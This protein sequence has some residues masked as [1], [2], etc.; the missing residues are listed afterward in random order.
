MLYAAD[1]SPAALEV[2]RAKYRTMRAMRLCRATEPDRVRT[3][4]RELSSRFPGALRE[5]DEL[6]LA[7][8]DAR[9]AAIEAAASGRGPV[10]GWAPTL[11]RYH[12]F[13]RVALRLKRAVRRDADLEAVSRWVLDHYRAGPDEPPG[14]EILG[15]AANI[16]RPPS[17]RLSRW[18]LGQIAAREGR[19]LAEVEREAFPPS[20]M[21]ARPGGRA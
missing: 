17:G 12:G 3:D 21:R 4:M 13:M 5:L 1:V 2:L 14:D 19:S 9:I 11:I 18:V 15:A 8:I 6:P 16:L 10:P 20:P 7:E